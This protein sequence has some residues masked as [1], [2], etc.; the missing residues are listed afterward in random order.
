MK[1]IHEVAFVFSSVMQQLV[2]IYFKQP[3]STPPLNPFYGH[4]CRLSS[5]RT[6]CSVP[7]GD[8]LRVTRVKGQPLELVLVCSGNEQKQYQ[9]RALC[10][11]M[12]LDH[13]HPHIVSSL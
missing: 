7:I 5:Q 4:K 9:E 6:F 3:L 10:D 1:R 2:V 8:L 13:T 11:V 12:S